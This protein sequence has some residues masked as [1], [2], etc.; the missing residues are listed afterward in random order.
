MSLFDVG[1]MTELLNRSLTGAAVIL[2]VLVLRLGMKRFPK[3]YVCLLWLAAFGRLLF[4][5]PVPSASGLFPAA[6]PLR[7]VAVEVDGRP[8]TGTVLQLSTGLEPVDSAVNELLWQL[9]EPAPLASA[10]PVQIYAFAFQWLWLGGMAVLL[11]TGLFRYGLLKRRISDAVPAEEA[12][13][14]VRGKRLERVYIT[15]RIQM[16]MVLGIWKPR[17]LLPSACSGE[18]R[19]G[20]RELILAHEQAHRLRYDHVTKVFVFGV[21]VIHWFNPLAWAAFLLYCRDVEMACD[22]KVMEWLGE[23][24]RK[25]Y[26][27]ALLRFEEERSALLIPLAFG[28]SSA[29]ERIRHILDYRKPGSWVTALAL[30]LVALAAGLFLMAPDGKVQDAVSIIG[31]ADGPTSIFLAGKVGEGDGEEKAPA[32]VLDL[33][34]E[35][36]E[37]YGAAAELDWVSGGKIS[38][39]GS[40]GYLS[41][42]LKANGKSELAAAFTLEE[43]GP[44]IVQGDRYTEVVGGRDSALVVTEAYKEGGDSRIFWYLEDGG[45]VEP[46]PEDMTNLF[47]E[48]SGSGVFRDAPL[49]E[50]YR[51]QVEEKIAEIPG[52]HLVYGPVEIP[53]TDSIICGFL[54]ADGPDLEDLWYGIWYEMDGRI[55]KYVLFP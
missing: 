24:S 22:E 28:E 5:I 54:A 1:T 51:Q 26:S 21:L 19:K 41:F 35:K 7:Q 31:G 50:E 9:L 10:D 16:P 17:V 49:A 27:L 32:A 20:E 14:T 25:P 11:L 30:L 13:C 2:A 33:E 45:T 48:Q 52:N 37:A 36:K 8:G 46:L 55:E 43:A 23:E 3:K 44:I 18:E 6:E 53:E 34:K 47:L 12:Q 4:F 42:L 38:L 29:R 39:H 15:D 40:F